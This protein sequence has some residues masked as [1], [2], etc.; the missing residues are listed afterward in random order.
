MQVVMSVYLDGKTGKYYFRKRIP[1]ELVPAYQEYAGTKAA[2][3]QYKRR[4]NTTDVKTAKKLGHQAEAEFEKLK[5]LLESQS[6]IT[7]ADLQ[8]I[9]IH[10]SM[11]GLKNTRQH[12]THELIEQLQEKVENELVRMRGIRASKG[13]DTLVKSVFSH[14]EPKDAVSYQKYLQIPGSE[15]SI[16]NLF[17]SFLGKLEKYDAKN[18]KKFAGKKNASANDL[19]KVLYDGAKIEQSDNHHSAFFRAGEGGY[20]SDIVDG[21]TGNLAH[22]RAVSDVELIPFY[23]RFELLPNSQYAIFAVEKFG[24][25]GVAFNIITGLKAFLAPKFSGYTV[26]IEPIFVGELYLKEYIENGEVKNIEATHYQ[27]PKDKASQQK[28]TVLTHHKVSL[29]PSRGRI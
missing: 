13:D 22:T 19:K 12:I 1:T 2:E 28:N 6:A 24:V 26:K 4:L 3:P 11:V 9:R 29:V 8:L 25:H 10:L 17:E 14:R 7:A 20:A 18:K 5:K 23:F 27:R 16:I 21:L 15:K